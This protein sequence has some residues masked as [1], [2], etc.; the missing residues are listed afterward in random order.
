MKNS[1]NISVIPPWTIHFQCDN[2]FPGDREKRE[3]V[4]YEKEKKS[5]YVTGFFCLPFC[6]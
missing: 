3:D 6:Y 5:L 4:L 2:Y 1:K